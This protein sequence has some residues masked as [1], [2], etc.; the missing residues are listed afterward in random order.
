EQGGFASALDADTAGHEGL[1]YVW[2]PPQLVAAL[3]AD[4][5]A[6]AAALLE[7]TADGT[8]E[9]GAST[10][11]LMRDPDDADRWAR[12]RATLFEV[13]AKREQPARDDKVV[14]AWNGLAMA[15]LADAAVLFDE[16][17]WLDAAV[18]AGDLLARVHAGA[19]PG[20]EGWLRRVSRDGTVGA[21]AGVLEDQGDVAEGFLALYAATGHARWLHRAGRLLDEVLD[22]FRAGDGS[23]FDTA[24]DAERLLRRPQ[25]PSDNATPS[26]T[27]AAAG[28][29]LSYAAYTG[30]SRH[31]EAAEQALG[32]Y[33]ELARRYPRFGG[34]G[35]AVA[36][37][38]L[39]G[40]REVAVAGRPGDPGFEELLAT[41][42]RGTAPGL[43]IAWSDPRAD[44]DQPV[45]LLVDRPM[46][47]GRA[48]AYV[49]RGFV[50]DAPTTDARVLA[51]AVSARGE[52]PPTGLALST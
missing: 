32:V 16:P 19:R 24:D 47:D 17:A 35:M 8:F 21:H 51:A 1:T 46:R 20:R 11:Q 18:R 27:S 33:A 3:G 49:C 52:Q 30:S 23:F 43:V 45:P 7:V 26:G 42:R 44:A 38:A 15:A 41:A 50:C 6:W 31:R 22:H 13:R 12:V 48:T 34:W 40:P 28:A 29:L 9:D 39:D 2:T 36:E 14:A 5:G 37:A 10:L 25:D 4:D